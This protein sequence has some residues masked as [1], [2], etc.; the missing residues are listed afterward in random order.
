[1]G[2]LR[3]LTGMR[4]GKLTAVERDSSIR[5]GRTFWICQCDCGEIVSV[6][7]NGLLTGNTQSCGCTRRDKLVARNKSNS[8]HG[9]KRNGEVE[10][11]YSIWES[12]KRRCYSQ[13]HEGY[14]YYGA[15]GIVVCDE[16][17]NDYESFKKWSLSNGYN[18]SLT[19]DRIN[20]DGNY[21]PENCR[22]T[23]AKEQANNRRNNRVVEYDGE[24]FTIAQ[25]SEK[26][27]LSYRTLDYRLS[28][29]WEVQ[30]AIE[31]PS[32]RRK[33]RATGN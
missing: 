14:K 27:G 32:K 1:M 28:H 24:R 9:A 7:S 18:K 8:T 5:A 4:F 33:S 21:C 22:W 2:A 25:L 30:K 11:L 13:S 19:I 6:R 3:D 10:R 23:S 16:W 12:M 31:Q 26:T 17:K 20:A 29:G 15:R